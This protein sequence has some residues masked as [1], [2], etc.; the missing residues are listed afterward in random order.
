MGILEILFLIF[1]TLKL[2]GTIDWSWW[3]VFAPLYPAMIVWSCII[4]VL[5][6]PTR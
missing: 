1:L 2:V 5:L 4:M 6:S 3:L